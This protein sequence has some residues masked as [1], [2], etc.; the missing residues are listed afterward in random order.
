MF[1]VTPYSL[2]LGGSTVVSATVAFLAWERRR[3]P[4]GTAFAA[5]MT[6]VVIWSLGSALETGA[7]GL[8]LKL[9]LAKLSY[10]G[11]VNTGPLFLMFALGYYRRGFR[12]PAAAHAFLW[13]VP[14]AALVLAAMA[15]RHGL[16]WRNLQPSQ[17]AGSNLLVYGHGPVYWILVAHA[18]LLVLAGTVV[19][20]Q[21][22]LRGQ[23]TSRASGP[24]VLAGTFLPWAGMVVYLTPLNPWPGLNVPVVAFALTGV[25]LIWGI[26]TRRLFSLVPVARD[27]LVEQMPDGLVVLDAQGRIQDANPRALSILGVTARVVGRFAA[28]ALAS[29]PAVAKAAA[30]FE[31]CHDDLRLG[32][33]QYYELRSTAVRDARGGVAGKLLHLRDI[34][35]RRQAEQGQERLIHELQAA[36][37]DVKILRGLLPICASCKKIRNDQGYW[38]HLE[39][40]ISEHSEAEFSHGLCPD[41]LQRLYPD[42]PPARGEGR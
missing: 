23:A 4:G 31:D 42:L 20:V 7:V 29:C 19:V 1:V 27:L 22:V 8:G 15:E 3:A 35:A 6:A 12:L 34:T 30:R 40:Y 41:C 5:M 13:G 36:L 9:Q 21:G 10:L 18:F 25:L 33:D 38:Q 39:G 17:V 16:I 32:Q 2:A 28:E 14:A 26:F 37:A 24:I 11:T